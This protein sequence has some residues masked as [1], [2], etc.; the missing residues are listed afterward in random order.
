MKK[1]ILLFALSLSS[2]AFGDAPVPLNGRCIQIPP[3]C[4]P[5]SYPMCICESDISM[6]CWYI[7]ASH[8]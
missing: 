4:P 5:G 1:M 3:I 6:K 7:C 2:L 8:G